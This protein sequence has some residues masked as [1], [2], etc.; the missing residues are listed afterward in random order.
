MWKEDEESGRRWTAAKWI[1]SKNIA[2]TVVNALQLPAL[3]ADDTSQFSYVKNL[4]REKS[5]SAGYCFNSPPC[6]H[7]SISTAASAR[8]HQHGS[9]STAAS[10]QQRPSLRSHFRSLV[11]A[12]EQLLTAAEL[13]GLVEF[14][15]EAVASLSKQ[16]TGSAEQLNDK[17]ASTAKFQVRSI[18]ALHRLAPPCPAFHRIPPCSHLV[19][20]DDLRLALPLLRRLG[21]AARPAEDVQGTSAHGE[22]PLQHDGV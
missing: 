13:T 9:I 21:V 19:S 3:S 15:C 20:S 12:V 14:T 2:Q 18:H 1:A 4:K 22:E 8:Q 16:S 6:Q 17:F 7:G 5:T 10:T 11:G